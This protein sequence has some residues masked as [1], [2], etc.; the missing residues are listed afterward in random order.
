MGRIITSSEEHYKALAEISKKADRCEISTFGIY[1][2]I[3]SDGRDMTEFGG[4]YGN[5]AHQFL[6]LLE[7]FD[8]KVLIGMPA[9]IYC[10]KDDKKCKNCEIKFISY[11]ERINHTAKHWKDYDW[12]IVDDMHMKYIGFYKGNKPVG[13]ISGGRN[14]SDSQWDDVSIILTKKEVEFFHDHFGKIFSRSAAITDNAINK[15][16]DAM[17]E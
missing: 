14:L 8:V 4:K 5:L 13:G 16:G 11:L 17:L 2:G 9:L 15:I 1:T 12:R 6:D 7:G 10:D 3:V